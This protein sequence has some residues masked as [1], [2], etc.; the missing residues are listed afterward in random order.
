MCV[1]LSTTCASDPWL[2][3]VDCLR[4]YGFSDHTPLRGDELDQFLNGCP[5]HLLVLK[6]TQCVQVEIKNDTTLAKL[7]DEEI[8]SSI[9][10]SICG[11]DTR[12][13]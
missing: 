2:Y 4:V 12:E 5:L 1:G 8:L 10:G 6:V 11:R 9:W 7:L 13:Y 3:H